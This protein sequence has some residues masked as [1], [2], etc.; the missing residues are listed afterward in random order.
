[1][2]LRGHPNKPP[3]EIMSK[4]GFVA[5]VG[6]PNAGKSSLLNAWVEEPLCPV[7][8]LPQTTRQCL[9]G[10]LT[11]ARGQAVFVDTPGMHTGHHQI[12][13]AM[14]EAI[15][16]SVDKQ[17]ADAIVYVVDLARKWGPEEQLISE[18]VASLRQPRAIVFNKSDRVAHPQKAAADFEK[19]LR[20]KLDCP[21]FL[22][23]ALKDTK[24]EEILDWL[25]DV[26][27]E[28]V[29]HFPPEYATDA[30][31]RFLGA[32]IIR[33]QVILNAR[34]EVP[35]AA[36][37]LVE[38]WKEEE[39]REA[40]KASIVVETQGQKAILIGKDGQK[41]K[42]I[43]QFSRREMK[44]MAGRPV[45]L[46]LFVKVRPKWRDNPR[47]LAELGMALEKKAKPEGK[48]T[49]KKSSD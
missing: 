31:M 34:G 8:P 7:T 6:R 44:A 9:R 5:L 25:F 23:S 3:T 45:A 18:L 14:V 19:R 47:F 27:P 39:E 48:R 11:E 15:R 13:W 46:E 33:R 1:M 41:I 49:R 36:C 20:A 40:V 24:R 17:E 29:P 28:G 43:R 32:E 42:Q 10:V 30:N 37:V 22:V 21:R 12:N 2:C 16:K 26:L 35:H 38:Q 4:F